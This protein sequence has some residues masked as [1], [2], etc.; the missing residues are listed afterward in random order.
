VCIAEL[1][2][3]NA[4]RSKAEVLH[5]VLSQEPHRNGVQKERS[6]S[7]EPDQTS[8]GV[9]LQE[10]LV[11]QK[12]TS[13]MLYTAAVVIIILWLLGMI[14]GYTV[15]GFIHILLVIALVMIIF[16]VIGGRKV[17]N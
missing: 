7:C 2:Q 3:Q 8:L 1:S 13:F 11:I 14:S 10:L 9:E 15:S 12:K 6:L 5:E 17:L 4:S 16:R